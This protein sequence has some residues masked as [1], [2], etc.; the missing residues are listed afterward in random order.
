MAWTWNGG[1]T[2]VECM[3]L[4]MEG[5]RARGRPRRT[6]EEDMGRSS[7]MATRVR[8]LMQPITYPVESGDQWTI[9]SSRGLAAAHKC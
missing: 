5:R 9:V 7:N 3:N 2:A 1:W 8:Q 4:Y 6:W